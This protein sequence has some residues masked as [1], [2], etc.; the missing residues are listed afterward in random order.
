MQFFTATLPPNSLYNF[1]DM[2]NDAYFLD[3]QIRI[4]LLI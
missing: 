4:Q 3:L 1:I 2:K